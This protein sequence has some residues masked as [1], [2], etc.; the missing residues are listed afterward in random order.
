MKVLFISP[1][2]PEEMQG[3]TR[4]LAEVGAQVYAVG[5]VPEAQLPG[6]VRKYISG[7]LR[8]DTL[9][10]EAAALAQILP[11][12]ARLQPDRVECLW[13]PCVLL[14]AALRER[15]DVPGMSRDRVL[16]FRDKT[17]MKTRLIEAGIRV[18]HFAKIRTAPEAFAAAESI[19]YPVVIKP[20]AGAGSADT[21]RVDS[22]AAMEGV[23]RQIGHLEEANLEEYID[24][25]EYT[26]DTVTIR[27]N[28]AFE[29]VT[30]YYP[31]PMEARHQEWVS[32]A[33]LTLRDPF[34]HP[35]VHAG[36][37][38]GR[39][40]LTALGMETGFTH[41][42]WFRKASGEVVFGEIAAR[43]P[44]GKLV[45]QMNFANDLDIFREWARA[46]CWHSFEATPHRRYYCAA[47]F[48]RAIGRGR[49]N[50]IRGLDA[51]R[52]RCGRGLVALELTPVG[53]PRR[54]WRNT[55]I[56]DG[57]AI[58]RHPDH[59]E[60]LRLM[61]QAISDLRLYAG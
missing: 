34:A 45:D 40:V 33:Q 23:L 44:G 50:A 52:R 19:G 28:P 26:Y 51:L 21:F 39:R 43:A 1:H 38:L 9:F 22:Q 10:D 58:I 59:H 20:I 47:V 11:F 36:I 32:P 56:G 25:E 3:F 46:V 48:K 7:Y 30:Q 35:E 16:G 2:Y 41:M 13:E 27:G 49:V 54:D 18:P 42:E 61:G 6:H 60:A 4:G 5:D 8:V 53:Q 55:L 14:A 57:F 15:L 31:K 17:L 24:G 37:E 12:A 29:S